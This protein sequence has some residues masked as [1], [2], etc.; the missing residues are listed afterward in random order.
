MIVACI[1]VIADFY[2]METIRFNVMRELSS[3][4]TI[5]ERINGIRKELLPFVALSE[6]SSL[7][8]FLILWWGLV[9][10]LLP[11]LLSEL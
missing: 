2:K 10:D 7:S 3:L 5:K 1:I 11:L 9:S 6:Y 8:T 4:P